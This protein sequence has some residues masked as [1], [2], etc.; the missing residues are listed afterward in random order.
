MN[1][2][3][4]VEDQ[5]DDIEHQHYLSLPPV[6]EIAPATILRT[7]E[8]ITAFHQGMRSM[9]LEGGYGMF[10]YL[11]TI[12]FFCKLKEVIHG[13]G[14][15]D[16][17]KKLLSAVIDEIKKHGKEYITSTGVKFELAETGTHYDYSNNV[18]WEELDALEK[19]ISTRKKALEE[20]LKK[21]PAGSELVDTETGEI[22]IGPTKTSK[23][24][25]KITL[26]K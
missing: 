15:Y 11:E 6:T 12:Q 21:I 26:P 14:K 10:E 24:S 23:S 25:F 1:N 13:A 3:L 22:L 8:N 19:D 5:Y 18:A 7:R 9:I 20:K 4:P 16:G 2:D 17:D